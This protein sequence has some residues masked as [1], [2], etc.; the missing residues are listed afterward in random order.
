M[1]M[2]LLS[3]MS[4]TVIETVTLALLGHT[5]RELLAVTVRV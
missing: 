3:L 4:L 2:G 1:N 5:L